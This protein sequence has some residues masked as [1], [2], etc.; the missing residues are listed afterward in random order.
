MLSSHLVI[1]EQQRVQG[2]GQVE[3]QRGGRCD[4]AGVH[5]HVDV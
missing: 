2:V 3:G 4:G 1:L 5:Q